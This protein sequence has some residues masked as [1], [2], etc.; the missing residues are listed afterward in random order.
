MSD[1]W[2]Y[3][4][5]TRT[6]SGELVVIDITEAIAKATHIEQQPDGNLGIFATA[7]LFHGDGEHNVVNTLIGLDAVRTQSDAEPKPATG[8]QWRIDP[9]AS[10]WLCQF[11]IHSFCAQGDKS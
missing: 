4:L 7:P 6:A 8:P 1:T 11:N 5:H 3:L 2:Q 10:R 9:E